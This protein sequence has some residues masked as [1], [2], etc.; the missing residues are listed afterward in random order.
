[1]KKLVLFIMMAVIMS[2]CKSCYS[3]YEQRRQG[4]QKVCKGCTYVRSEGWDIA[5]DTTKQPNIIYKVSFCSGGFYY[6]AW[7][8]NHLTRIN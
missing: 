3:D 6:N 1:M 4:V 7:D 5:V 8:V 2:G